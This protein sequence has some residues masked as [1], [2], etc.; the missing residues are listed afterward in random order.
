MHQITTP[1]EQKYTSSKLLRE[2]VLGVSHIIAWA[3]VNLDNVRAIVNL[4]CGANEHH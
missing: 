2:P 3:I 4:M 1:Y